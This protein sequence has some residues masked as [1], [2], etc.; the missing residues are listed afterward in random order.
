MLF[1]EGNLLPDDED[2]V[3]QLL[4]SSPKV[5]DFCCARFSSDQQWYRAQVEQINVLRNK[6]CIIT[7]SKI[8]KL[9]FKINKMVF[10]TANVFDLIDHHQV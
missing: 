3:S 1:S 9:Y 5:G 7:P 8:D 10:K 2:E 6:R 4:T